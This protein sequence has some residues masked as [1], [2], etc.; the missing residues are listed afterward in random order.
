M[1]RIPEEPPSWPAAP[2]PEAVLDDLRRQI[3]AAKARL[4]EHRDQMLAAGL[5]GTSDD[6]SDAEAST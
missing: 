2:D 6:A 4:S 1:S 3:E 5:A